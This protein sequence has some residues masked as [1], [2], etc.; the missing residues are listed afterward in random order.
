MNGKINGLPVKLDVHL[1]NQ[2]ILKTSIPDNDRG[3]PD[4][5]S[6]RY[7]KI[8]WRVRHGIFHKN[9]TI[10]QKRVS[11]KTILFPPDILLLNGKLFTYASGIHSRSAN[12]YYAFV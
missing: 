12:L 7:K 11:I 2:S 6:G 1:T 3:S 9:D 5:H 8:P 10:F 4:P